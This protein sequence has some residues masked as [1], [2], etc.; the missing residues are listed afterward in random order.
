LNAT[1]Y[2]WL[3]LLFP[4]AGSVV[5][6]LGWRW[7]PGRTAGWIG[8]AAIGIA[9]LNSIAMLLR[10][11]DRPPEERH[12][13]SSLWDYAN[14]AGIDVKVEVFVDPLAVF[15]C[16]VVT[17]V[18]FLIHV[19]SVTYMG[20]D[21]GFRRYFSY[22]NFFVFSMLLLVLAGNFV[23]LIIG[24]A[25]V[26]F[27]SY[28]LISFWYRRR[29][30]TSAGMKAFVINVI[31]D[32]GLVLAAI[33]IQRDT[34]RLDYPGVFEAA[35]R[36]FEQNEWIIVAICLLILVGAFAKSAQIPLHTWLPDAMEGPTPV[37]ALIHAATMVT[38]GV[39]LIARMHPLF[40]LGP[41]AADISAAIGALTIVFAASVALV[42][43]DLKRI[44]AYSTISQIGYMIV[45]VSIAAYGAGMFHLMT[46]A[47]FKAL[48][49]MAAGSV[50]GAMAGRQDID[51]MRGLRRAL[52]FTFWTFLI[53][54]L[55]LAAFP[56]FSG[57]FSKD[58]ILAFAAERGGAYWLLYAA[59]TLAALMTAFYAFRIMFRVFGG[60]P[61]DEA[62][63]IESKGHLHTDPVNPMTG[64]PEDTDI[65]Y[66]GPEHHTAEHERPMQFAMVILAGLAVVAGVLQIPGVTH[67]VENFLHPTFEDS[68][69]AETD[70]SGSLEALALIVG[71]LTALG[72]IGLAWL[73][74]VHHPGSTLRLA[75]RMPR[76]HGFLEHKWYFDELYDRAI[77]RPALA[78][79]RFSSDVIERVVIGGM[80]S[81]TAHAVRAGNSLV[82]VAQTGL[83][84]NY[85]LL[86]VTGVTAL[87]LYFLVV[88]R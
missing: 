27:A 79:G 42:V 11:Q 59:G 81:G 75:R 12:L 73:L 61:N 58:E 56:G 65:G 21:R 13:I 30:A 28:A 22:L 69:F 76:L 86:L 6:A 49:F 87:A 25:F 39:Y 4:L 88:S 32:V 67:V 5:I 72:G 10:L 85:A 44:I 54:A 29:T 20:G 66:P 37:S 53:A 60:E 34:G 68:R 52:P 57:Y 23:L 18:S 26:G 36:V 1:T 14:T 31:G 83:L 80:V 19:Y 74:Y 47:F 63:E 77:V 40:E 24:W 8:S 48:M 43:T 71:G 35:P 46:H 38:A 62:R 84:R 16:L 51:G 33:L 2:A 55:A 78:L 70:V 50:I 82:R 41:T 9:F 64:E 17:G 7:L 45:A 3:V 15:M